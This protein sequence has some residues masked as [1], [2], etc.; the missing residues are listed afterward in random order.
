LRL[1]SIIGTAALIITAALVLSSCGLDSGFNSIADF[2]VIVTIYDDEADFG[3]IQTYA[4]PDSVAYL[5]DDKGGSGRS[6]D[7]GIYDQLILDELAANLEAIGYVREE[8]PE[9]NGADVVVL[10]GVTS[11]DWEVWVSNPWYDWGYW[12]YYSDYYYYYPP[13]YG[14]GSSYTFTTGS[15]LVIMEDRN[16]ADHDEETIPVIWAAGLNG[17]LEGSTSSINNRI[18]DGIEQAFAQSSYLGAD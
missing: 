11:T 9:N 14:C 6:R 1:S 13:C 16:E 5:G 8:D 15:L 3:A 10:A 4:M 18:I 7:E 2:D 17:L 12:G